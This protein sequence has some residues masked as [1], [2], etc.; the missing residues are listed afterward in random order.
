MDKPEQTRLPIWLQYA[1]QELGV[2]EYSGLSDNPEIIKYFQEVS[3]GEI[4]NDETPWCAAFVGAMLE[5]AEIQSTKSLMARSYLRWGSK[6][7]ELK[8]GAIVILKR[9]N[10]NVLGHVGFVI[11]SSQS[12]AQLLSGNQSN[13][14]TISSFNKSDILD[15]RWPSDFKNSEAYQT[16]Q[17]NKITPSEHFNVAFEHILNVEGEWSDHKLDRG[18]PTYKG[19]TLTTLERAI[20]DG[21]IAVNHDDQ[22]S[23]LKHLK[24]N[25]VKKIYHSYYWRMASCHLFHPSIAI[26]LFDAAVN[27]GPKTA[28]RLL[29][30]NVQAS[31]DGE[32]GPETI[33][34]TN[35]TKIENTLNTFIKHRETHYRSLSQFNIFGK[36][37]LN[38]LKK[39]EAA[40]R[41]QLSSSFHPIEKYNHNSSKE[42]KH[43]NEPISNTQSKWWGESLTVWGTII[44]ALSTVLPVMGPF[45]GLNISAELILQFGDTVAKLIQIIGGITGTTMALYGRAR[46]NQQLVRK[47]MAIKL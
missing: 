14:V 38:R 29:Q 31:V 4:A 24:D 35:N 26:V 45:I 27:H 21:L 37:W 44:T 39:T 30:K 1:M 3:H 47:P 20:K 46:A 13:K 43:M 12:H 42:T 19:I 36:G 11:S 2:S 41:L 34:K 32:V 16:S 8:L 6:L 23:A 17:L 10:N 9:G 5:R 40:A 15:I 25:Q 7:E 18:G 28:I 33:A 22:I